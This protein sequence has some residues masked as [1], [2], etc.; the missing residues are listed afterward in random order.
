MGIIVSILIIAIMTG[1]HHVMKQPYVNMGQFF[2][3]ETFTKDAG[4][5]GLIIS[6]KTAAKFVERW[7]KDF[8]VFVRMERMVVLLRPLMAAMILMRTVII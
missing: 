5:D 1:L 3:K 8:V 7:Y 6:D 4:E 2:R